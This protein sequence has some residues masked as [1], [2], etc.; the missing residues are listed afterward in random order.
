MKCLYCEK[1]HKNK[2]Y[3]SIKCKN[4]Y[5][6][7]H[8][9]NPFS[10]SDI[11]KKISNNG[12]NKAKETQIKKYGKNYA[13]IR[14]K[15]GWINKNERKIKFNETYKN[16]CIQKYGID[17]VF[18]LPEMRLKQGKKSAE[19]F[20]K[21]LFWK[22][23]KY[24]YH[25]YEFRSSW[26]LNFAKILI[27][28]N[29]KFKYEPQYFETKFG[30]YIPDFYIPKYNLWIEIKGYKSKK[31][32]QK[33]VEFSKKYISGFIDNDIYKKLINN[34]LNINELLMYFKENYSINVWN[35]L[36]EE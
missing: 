35:K 11:Q 28:N 36:L 10:R 27:L 7:S 1:E 13:S 33:F 34:N 8:N 12:K 19:I 31:S 17:N 16:T 29:I 30:Y 32:I 2:K 15:K 6:V 20:Q 23:K 3:C 24:K 18:K 5:E 25:D 26:E 14:A 21:G 22:T 4:K 9:I